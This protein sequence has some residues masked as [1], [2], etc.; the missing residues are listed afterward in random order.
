MIF[1]FN[2]FVYLSLYPNPF[3][4]H[5]ESLLHS[6]F[7]IAPTIQKCNLA[8]FSYSYDT[9]F[10]FF[11]IILPNSYCPAHNSANGSAYYLGYICTTIMP[12]LPSILNTFITSALVSGATSETSISCFELSTNIRYLSFG[13]QLRILV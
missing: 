10:I 2:R 7:S 9:P 13:Y 12:I 4:I 5:V 11:S 1:F 8:T 6:K 3:I